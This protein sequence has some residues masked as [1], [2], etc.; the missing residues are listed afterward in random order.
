MTVINTN[1]AALLTAN[2]I[3]INERNM[4][5]TM[6]RLSTGQ[7]INSAADD[8]AGLAISNRMTSQ[9]RGLEQAGRNA[10]NATSMV[11]L[12]DGAAEQI[13]NILQ[14][15][16]ELVVQ[17]ADG[18][19]EA[20]DVALLNVEFVEAAKEIDRI[21]DVTEFN[22]KNL[23]SGNVG[24][25]GSS[26]VTF[27]M[28]ANAG[29]TL[30]VDF[31]DFNLAAGGTAIADAV[32]TAGDTTTAGVLTYTLDVTTMDAGDRLTIADV[33]YTVTGN[34]ADNT[35]LV[36]ALNASTDSTLS[37]F[38]FTGT[39]TVVATAAVPGNTGTVTT[40]TLADINR[41]TGPMS[42]NL[43]SFATTGFDSDLTTTLEKI[44][45]AIDGVAT[46]RAV[47]GATMNRLEYAIDNLSSSSIATSSARSRI[48]DANYA[49]ETTALA[50]TQIISQAST[51][52]LAQANQKSQTVMQLL[53]G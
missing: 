1:S 5:K 21:T 30:D 45:S 7:R 3:N 11:T 37:Q 10:N 12:A 31:A 41:E 22:G 36:A 48:V 27:Q 24:G 13:T 51:A 47:F 52:M 16:R 46:Q 6:E 53:Q 43:S 40:S 18:S 39:T 28:G 38:N 44:E 35:D 15:M 14:R 29:Q 9:I 20:T 42:G 8:A 2:S 17:A 34:E 25:V 19:N 49:T 32:T 26:I 50:K 23:L 33:S 4:T